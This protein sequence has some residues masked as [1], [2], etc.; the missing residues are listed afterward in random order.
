MGGHVT[1]RRRQ[2]KRRVR[3]AK[4]ELH[5][6]KTLEGAGVGKFKEW[7]TSKPMDKCA[8][9]WWKDDSSQCKNN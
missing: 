6:K 8:M 7:L 5:V 1:G 2:R 3:L 4:P 9:K